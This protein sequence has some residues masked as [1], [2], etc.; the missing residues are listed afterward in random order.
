MTQA[1]V[2]Q[3]DKKRTK[4]KGNLVF[5]SKFFQQGLR[6]ASVWPSSKA[7]SK[8]TVTHVDWDKA[9]VIVEL[10]AGTGPV[11]EVI[12]SKLKPHTRFISIERD[13]DLY[14]I[15]AERCAGLPNV[16]V[17]H[18]DAADLEKILQER[19]IEK[20]DYIISCLATPSL[21]EPVRDSVWQSVRKYLSPHGVYSNITEFPLIYWKY[22]K[23]FF[24]DVDF[25]F[26]PVNF[27]PAGVYHCRAVREA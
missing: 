7:L 8:A 15:V 4:L 9:K 22:Y 11:T 24:H 6:I 18:R 5:L 17:L 14:N 12:I 23:S 3:Q 1:A 19:G 25:K 13:E 10:G 26:V 20:V 27:P 16:E 2:E 21:P